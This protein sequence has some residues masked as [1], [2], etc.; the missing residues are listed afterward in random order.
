MLGAS[1]GF[2]SWR[3]SSWVVCPPFLI[4]GSM[5]ISSGWSTNLINNPHLWHLWHRLVLLHED[6]IGCESLRQTLRQRGQV[7]CRTACSAAHGVS[8]RWCRPFMV[9]LGM[10]STLPWDDGKWKWNPSAGSQK[11]KDKSNTSTGCSS[12]PA[13]ELDS[14]VWIQMMVSL[15][16]PKNAGEFGYVDWEH[17]AIVDTTSR[18]S[19]AFVQ[20]QK[21]TR[22]FGAGS[23]ADHFYIY[24]ENGPRKR[25][26]CTCKVGI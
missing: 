7:G 17:I 4:H 10:G 5:V 21:N 15:H 8:F 12:K 13:S 9:P 6:L 23:G 14:H 24:W 1:R 11:S 20:G 18:T 19:D 25:A 3:I 16:P 22:L 26:H 2:L